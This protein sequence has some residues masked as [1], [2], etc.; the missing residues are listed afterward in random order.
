MKI[1]LN[2]GLTSN[3]NFSS[4]NDEAYLSE[5]FHQSLFEARNGLHISDP[6]NNYSVIGAY[7][8]I[9][10][11][12]SLHRQQLIKEVDEISYFYLIDVICSLLTEDTL[13]PEIGTNNVLSLKYP[14]DEKINK[15]LEDLEYNLN[16]DELVINIF[17]DL[18][19]YGEYAVRIE[20]DALEPLT[21]LSTQFNTKPDKKTKSKSKG[22]VNVSDTVDQGTVVQLVQDGAL[23]GYLALTDD[24]TKVIK[25]AP[26]K[27]VVFSLNGSKKR[28]KLHDYIPVTMLGNDKVA[29]IVRKMPQFIRIGKSLI[30]G[31]I[32]KFRE[33]EL[34]EK[35]VP[36]TK[37]SKL[38]NVNLVGV[39][40]PAKY[41]INSGFD[42]AR[43]M[44][45]YVNNKVGVDQRLG[46]I[47]VESILSV[48]G[49]TKVLP[50]FGDKGTVQ[51][52][53]HESNEPEELLSSVKDLREVILDSIGIPSELVYRSDSEGKAE[54]LKR[55][56][57]YL[58]KLKSLQRAV[59]EGVKQIAII[60][61]QA[62]G[63]DFKPAE[64]EVEL[65]NKLPEID[66]IDRLEQADA[67]ISVIGNIINFFKDLKDESHP[68]ASIIKLDAV[69]SYVDRQLKTIGLSDA[70]VT[71]DEGGKS[72]DLIKEPI[73]PSG[74]PEP[75]DDLPTDDLPDSDDDSFD[76]N[77]DLS[78]T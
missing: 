69:A 51:K 1:K 5:Q 34:L 66:N 67:T 21:D 46:E 32:P 60:H 78:N 37:L 64:I 39:Q 15:I 11:K 70:I 30:H 73:E 9:Y 12:V 59:V 3:T 75:E 61:L 33:L 14:S 29:E 77:D 40:V 72:I 31:M 4:I 19:K 50:L 20:H 53:D 76:Q 44:E 41:D 49:R 42:V 22:I 63:V 52:I 8:S 58:R 71:V 62:I 38:S 6:Y 10:Q 17:P 57:R 54:I 13:A 74:Q 2:S 55:N 65:C 24:K 28:I 36:A 18:I 16:L 68:M 7:S 26:S 27:Y 23:E 43:R 25:T 48:A 47:T 45:N 35:L 56:S